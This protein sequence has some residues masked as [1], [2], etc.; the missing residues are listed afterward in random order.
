MSDQ[1]SLWLTM[2]RPASLMVVD[3]AMVLG[4]R[5]PVAEVRRVFGTAIERFPVL[6]RRPVKVGSGWAWEDDPDFDVARHVSSVT[7]PAP[8]DMRALQ[9]FL[10]EKRAEP[11]DKTRPVWLAYHVRNLKLEDGRKGSAIVTRFHHALADGV[12]LTQ[13]MLSLCDGEHHGVSAVVAHQ[14]S[15][16]TDPIAVAGGAVNLAA[17]MGL[18]AVAATTGLLTH[19]GRTLAKGPGAVLDQVVGA[20]DEMRRPERWSEAM[21]TLGVDEHRATAD[22][23]TLAKIAGSSSP[24]TIWTG[25]PGKRKAVAWTPPIPLDDIKLVGRHHRCTVN[26]V[27][28]SAVSGALARYL[29]ERNAL[30]DQVMWMVPVNLKP[31]ERTLPSELGNYFALVFLP[32]P[33]D[34]PNRR[35]RLKRM[36]GHMKRIKASDEA[37]ITF[38]MQR[39]VSW[40]PSPMATALTNFFADKAVGVLTNV[41]GPRRA[42]TFAGSPVLQVVGFAPCSGKQPMTATIFSYAGAVTV[43]FASDFGLVPDPDVLS[44]Y[45]FDEVAAMVDEVGPSREAAA[46][47]QA[48]R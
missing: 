6:R 5:P 45:V 36:H 25:K 11:M 44:A 16:T 21:G 32:M 12:R 27:L 9:E 42:M 43:G 2:D 14:P 30:V 40:S 37:V 46:D 35:T 41:P 23:S 48:G 28:I 38:G 47:P 19:T 29:E 31:H 39:I 33:L 3:G 15:V 24:E 34:D 17:G 20:L 22:L 13:L 26:D 8:A 7:L 18:D 1:D 4:S 10:A